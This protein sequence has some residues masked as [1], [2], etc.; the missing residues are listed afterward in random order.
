MCSETI[1]FTTELF[2]DDLAKSANE[3][4]ETAKLGN[5]VKGGTTGGSFKA[6]SPMRGGSRSKP[7]PPRNYDNNNN[8]N[9][10]RDFGSR[11]QK[12]FPRRKRKR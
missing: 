6:K 2:G 9:N 8:N 10:N 4:G 1:P 12:K 3:I 5:T 7:Y 11:L